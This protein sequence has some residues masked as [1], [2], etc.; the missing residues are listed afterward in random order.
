MSVV[1]SFKRNCGLE[2]WAES[3][4]WNLSDH[5]ALAE[6][7]FGW[8]PQAPLM[9][10][11]PTANAQHCPTYRQKAAERS[12]IMPSHEALCIY[13]RSLPESWEPWRCHDEVCY[14]KDWRAC[15][16]RMHRQR[17]RI[18][19]SYNDE[20]SPLKHDRWKN[21]LHIFW[22]LL[23][24]AEVSMTHDLGLNSLP[25]LKSPKSPQIVCLLESFWS[26][27]FTLIV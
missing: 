4:G 21:L 13:P 23:I 7:Y 11:I 10:L 17:R 5:L 2:V 1:C 20:S 3:D 26:L 6:I 9:I 22:I 14:H 19:A 15:R 12:W 8:Y 16:S 24:F 27:P 25:K 18:H